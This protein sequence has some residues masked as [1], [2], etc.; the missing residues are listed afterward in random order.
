[1]T[2][3]QKANP[4]LDHCEDCGCPLDE[5]ETVYCSYCLENDY[6]EEYYREKADEERERKAIECSCGA[7]KMGKD[8]KVYHVA[9]CFCGAE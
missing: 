8:G 9:D 2:Q 1:M 3:Q 4:E 5:T 6:D 7:W